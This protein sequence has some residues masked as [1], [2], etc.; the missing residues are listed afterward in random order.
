MAA[1]DQIFERQRKKA[2]QAVNA[3]TQGKTEAL[4]RRFASLGAANSGAQIK[5]ET[6]ARDEGTRQLQNANEAIDSAEIQETQRRDEIDQ[7]RQFATSERV[8]S[9]GFGAE[10]AALQRRFQTGE[11]QSSQTFGAEQSA[12]QRKFAT[13][14]RLSSQDFAGVQAELQR[15]FASGER[16]SQNEFASLEALKN[17][18]FAAAENLL[19][20][21]HQSSQ[22]NADM[23]FKDRA[24]ADSN[25]QFDQ[26]RFDIDQQFKHQIFIDEKNLE[27][28]DKI[29]NEKGTIEQIIND[30]AGAFKKFTTDPIGHVSG[31]GP[32]NPVGKLFK[33]FTIDPV[34]KL[35]GLF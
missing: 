17:R 13:G 10:Q 18:D 3:Q 7:A 33:T 5:Q 6:I 9:Q 28:A 23:A 31:G 1:I 20:R 27:L 25:R 8:A 22:F 32:G 29:A 4:K 30:P 2:S 16:L 26:N 11:R 35:G 19:Q 12:L 34:K 15:K 14:E 24:L 21:D